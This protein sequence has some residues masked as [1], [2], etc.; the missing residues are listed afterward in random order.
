MSHMWNCCRDV[1]FIQVFCSIAFLITEHELTVSV[2]VALLARLNSVDAAS[3]MYSHIWS[4]PWLKLDVVKSY[5]VVVLGIFVII[6]VVRNG[7]AL[8]SVDIRL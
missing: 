1:I 5:L 6:G 8:I 3:S 7:E 4:F 2:H